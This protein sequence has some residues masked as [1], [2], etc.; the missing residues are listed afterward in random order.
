FGLLSTD[1]RFDVIQ[2]FF[3]L[4]ATK[5]DIFSEMAEIVP[6]AIKRKRPQDQVCVQT[7]IFSH[8]HLGAVKAAQDRVEDISR[9]E[10]VQILLDKSSEATRLFAAQGCLF[11][12]DFKSHAQISSSR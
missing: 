7:G 4:S 6:A 9:R 5:C 8:A 11:A 1:E 10:V 12:I 3:G 2:V